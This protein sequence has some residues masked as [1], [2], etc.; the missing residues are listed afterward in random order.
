MNLYLQVN[1]SSI[2]KSIT[3]EFPFIEISTIPPPA[4]DV[5]ILEAFYLFAFCAI[6]LEIDLTYHLNLSFF[7]SIPSNIITSLLSSFVINSILFFHQLKQQLV[8]N[9]QVQ[10]SYEA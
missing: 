10:P 3:S 9:F 8:Y 4:F 7:K 6:S 5:K 2:F 1:E